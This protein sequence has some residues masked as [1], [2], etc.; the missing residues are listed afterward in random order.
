[1][2]LFFDLY[3]TITGVGLALSLLSR[4]SY[5]YGTLKSNR[6]H[7]LYLLAAVA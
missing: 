3:D 5:P 1:L 6:Y 2:F 4:C 7:L